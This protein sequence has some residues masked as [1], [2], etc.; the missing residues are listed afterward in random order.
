MKLGL[1]SFAFTLTLLSC[2]PAEQQQAAKVEQ[3]I[4][5]VLSDE[6]KACLAA[7]YLPGTAGVDAKLFCAITQPWTQAA[8]AFLKLIDAQRAR[9]QDGGAP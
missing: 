7:A 9:L 4:Q 6:D 3:G 1:V 8:D 5:A 2:T